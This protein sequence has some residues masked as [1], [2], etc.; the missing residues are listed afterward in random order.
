MRFGRL[1]RRLDGRLAAH[2]RAHARRDRSRVSTPAGG[3]GGDSDDDPHARLQRAQLLELF[4]H[5]QIARRQCGQRLQ[6]A[7]R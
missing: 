4:R 1:I 5:F 3:A 7:T 2:Q 6:R